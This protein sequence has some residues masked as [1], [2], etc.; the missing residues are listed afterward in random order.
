MYE[1]LG[2]PWKGLWTLPVA[3]ALFLLVCHAF[4]V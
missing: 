4:G 2:S 3:I 1:P